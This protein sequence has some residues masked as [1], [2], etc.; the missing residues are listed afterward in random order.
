MNWAVTVE[1]PP[2]G[3]GAGIDQRSVR[4][5]TPIE[6]TQRLGDAR[7]PPT[8]DRRPNHAS[9]TARIVSQPTSR[10]RRPAGD[11]RLRGANVHRY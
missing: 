1:R 3:L 4:P 9:M 7:R 8:A 5:A 6:R 2:H 10:R 11:V